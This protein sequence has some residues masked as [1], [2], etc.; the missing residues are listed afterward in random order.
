MSASGESA[1]CECESAQPHS[2]SARG[3]HPHNSAMRA[4]WDAG[5]GAIMRSSATASSGC[6]S[7][8]GSARGC[9]CGTPTALRQVSSSCRRGAR[10]RRA[11]SSST[12]AVA[13]SG[14]WE[15]RSQRSINS[16]VERVT[17]APR[18]WRGT[19]GRG[20]C[21][22]L[23]QQ[24]EKGRLGPPVEKGTQPLW[25]EKGRGSGCRPLRRNFRHA[26]DAGGVG[27]ASSLIC[28]SDAVATLGK[29]SAAAMA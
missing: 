6:S 28:R 8:T 3:M 19:G 18:S 13:V 23:W 21:Q 7:V 10:R 12:K 26:R 24:G 4:A 16:R 22:E 17:S 29:R 5:T 14:C 15:S 2:L 11:E 27:L 1:S 25:R 20:G 9:S